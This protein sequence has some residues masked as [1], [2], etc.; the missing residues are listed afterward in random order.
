MYKSFKRLFDILGSVTGILLSSPLMIL[1][2][3]AVWIY[4]R[5]SPIYFANRVGCKGKVFTMYKIR[6][7]RVGA[8]KSGVDS[9]SS[10]DN[11]ITPPGKLVRRFKI[12]EVMQ[13]WNVLG[14]KMSLVGPRPN[15]EKETRLYTQQ[16]QLL[17]SVK[18][19][20]TDFASI[21]FADEGEILSNYSDPDIAYHQL[22][23]P[24]KNSLALY[25]VNN[26]S[27]SLDLRIILLTISSIFSRSS[28]LKSLSRYLKKLGA[29]PVL[30]ELAL[31]NTPLLPSPPPG[32]KN[33]VVSRD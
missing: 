23:R 3:M 13:F 25:Y 6:S 4:D 28:T 18:P 11:R 8:D 12:D 21:V 2:L 9:T 31:R 16:E 27:L 10:S 24:G 19:G 15:I 26:S 5:K 32:S 7:M 1:A 33:I 20:I 22:I 29:P 17:L 14:G 30:I